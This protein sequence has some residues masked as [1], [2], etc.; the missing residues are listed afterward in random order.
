MKTVF[1]NHPLVCTGIGLIV[2]GIA[3]LLLSD[4]ARK[5]G[6]DTVGFGLMWGLSFGAFFAIAGIVVLIIAFFARLM[7][8]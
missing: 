2:I 4:L 7:K 5:L 8:Q 1:R 3:P 6:L